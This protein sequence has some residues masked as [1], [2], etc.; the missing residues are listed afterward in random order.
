MKPMMKKKIGKAIEKAM[1]KGE[2]KM[3]KMPKGKSTKPAMKKKMKMD[4]Y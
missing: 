1:A 4:N 3:E 2:G